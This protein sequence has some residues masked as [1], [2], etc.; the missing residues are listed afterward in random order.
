MKGGGLI[1]QNSTERG[2]LLIPVSVDDLLKEFDA[3]AEEI[4]KTWQKEVSAVEAIREDRER[5]WLK[6]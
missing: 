4:G 2:V 6:K 5:R 1:E 3:L